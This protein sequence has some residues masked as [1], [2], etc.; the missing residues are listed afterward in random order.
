[1][2]PQPDP[3]R[4]FERDGSARPTSA[5][6]QQ[7]T[8]SDKANHCA[9]QSLGEE[10]ADVEKAESLQ[11]TLRVT[12]PARPRLTTSRKRVLRG[13]T[14]SAEGGKLRSVNSECA[15]SRVLDEVNGGLRPSRSEGPPRAQCTGRLTEPRNL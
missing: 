11:G 1:M 7:A 3:S 2:L 6:E 13:R 5:V 8:G 4:L 15:K 10:D 12:S 14:T 9:R